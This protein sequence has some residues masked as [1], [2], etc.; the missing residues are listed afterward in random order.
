MSTLI[1]CLCFTQACN[2]KLPNQSIDQEQ[3]EKNHKQE[4]LK[5][6]KNKLLSDQN[7][8]I[9]D[10]TQV[11]NSLEDFLKLERFVGKVVYLDFWGTGCKPCIKEFAYLPD[12]K[13]KFK[14]EPVEYVYV[15][16]YRKK[17]SD[18]FYSKT[19]RALIEKHKLTGVNL[20]ISN[21]AK[22]R[23]YER[24]R[25]IVDPEWAHIVPVYLLINKE[26]TVINYVAPRPSSKEILYAEI[27][28][29]LVN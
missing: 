1:I 20:R 22:L 26:G 7:C 17:E 8:I 14:N 13:K 23:F 24:H 28:E 6:I 21:D 27:Q 10:S 29:M 18:S 19:W 12:L 3:K 25:N 11:F 16:T 9:Y 4:R 2:S 15:T 5:A